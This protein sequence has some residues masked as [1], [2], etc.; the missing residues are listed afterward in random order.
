[1][2]SL[3]P[4]IV[5]LLIGLVVLGAWLASVAARQRRDALRT[6][7]GQLGWTFDPERVPGGHAEL[8]ALEPFQRG[9]SQV[10]YN[11]M[12]GRLAGGE[13][14]CQAVAGDFQYRETHGSGKDRR[15][16]THT[17]SYVV[18][19]LPFAVPDL[20]IRREG[21]LDKVAGFF[22][23][24]DV[25]FESAEFSRR[26]MVRCS[27]RK[28]A[29]DLIDPRMMEL[30]LTVDPPPLRTAGCLLCATDASSEWT[31]AVFARQ[32]EFARRFLEHWPRHLVASLE[33][34]RP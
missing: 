12:R 10:A 22:G 29:Y 6:L 31:P 23:F 21:L 7:A 4:L 18:L 30:F 16:S 25:D 1:M 9:D 34:G 32:I 24:D 17:L 33:E 8:Q 19:E 15:T 3:L 20:E 27:D 14:A 28:F 5:A 2:D 13:L 11:T 26:F